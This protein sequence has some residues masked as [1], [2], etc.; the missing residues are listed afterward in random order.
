MRR[1]IQIAL[2]NGMSPAVANKLAWSRLKALESRFQGVL[3]SAKLDPYTRAH[4]E[5]LENKSTQARTAE[6][7]HIASGGC[8]LT[9]PGEPARPWALGGLAAVVIGALWLR[10]RAAA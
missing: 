5:S 1:L 4:L 7:V 10:R 9:T 3:A 8:A 6:Y 2:G